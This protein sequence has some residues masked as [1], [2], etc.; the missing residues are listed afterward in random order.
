MFTAIR[1]A[2]SSGAGRAGISGGGTASGGAAA[3]G[4]AAGGASAGGAAAGSAP[5][6]A[7]C[8]GSP[9]RS[10]GT[11]ASRAA[12]TRSPKTTSRPRLAGRSATGSRS[13]IGSRVGTGSGSGTTSR[14]GTGGFGIGGGR[15]RGDRS[16]RLGRGQRRHPLVPRARLGPIGPGRA[17]G[18]PSLRGRARWQACEAPGESPPIRSG[19]APPPRDRRAGP[20]PWERRRGRDAR[21]CTRQSHP[22]S[23]AH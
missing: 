9:P 16:G 6:V 17:S 18:R 2:D 23:S 1:S 7:S 13:G 8:Q 10:S 4:A 11:A 5:G 14:V 15:L 21:G 22:R 12:I 20:G 3:G 19:A